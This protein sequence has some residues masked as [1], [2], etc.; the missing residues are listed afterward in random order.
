MVVRVGVEI[1]VGVRGLAINFIAQWAIRFTVDVNIKEG[2]MAVPFGLHRELNALM[3]TVQAIKELR[4]IA[5]T[6]GQDDERVIHVAK[7]AERLLGRPLQ[8][9]FLKVLH[10]EVGDVRG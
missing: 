10:E 8:S 4:Q 3:D 2:K 9:C 5:W 6:M 7:P 1:V